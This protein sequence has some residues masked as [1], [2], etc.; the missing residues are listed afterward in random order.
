MKDEEWPFEVSSGL[1]DHSKRSTLGLPP[2]AGAETFTIFAPNDDNANETC[3][4]LPFCPKFNHG[5]HIGSFEG[6]LR[7]TWQA[8]PTGEDS[9]DGIHVSSISTDDGQT[10]SPPQAGRLTVHAQEGENALKP[11]EE[12]QPRKEAPAPT[13]GGVPPAEGTLS[14]RYELRYFGNDY[15]WHGPGPRRTEYTTS[16]DGVNWSAWQFLKDNEG[17][18]IDGYLRPAMHLPDGRLITWDSRIT[19]S[20]RLVSVPFYT[21]DPAGIEGWTRAERQNLPCDNEVLGR[22]LESSFFHRADGRLVVV[23][24]DIMCVGH[25]LATMMMDRGE[26]WTP[27]VQTNMPDLETNETAGNLSDGTAFLVNHPTAH[28]WCSPG[29]GQTP[30]GPREMLA[31]TLS[32]DGRLFDRSYLIRGI[33]DLQPK[34]YEGRYKSTGYSYPSAT[35]IGDNMY[36]SYGTN[37]EDAEVTRIPLKSLM[38]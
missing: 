12:P 25:M 22:E 20:D 34:R 21:D 15:F 23:F 31:I 5:V 19:E 28:E 29:S 1:F 35:I 8:C 16:A 18:F 36:V 38:L 14:A 33:D 13:P 26:R 32:K 17:N 7:A 6:G 37:K 27:V 4:N 24:R 9:A 2:V 30:H 10:W 11:G 3:A